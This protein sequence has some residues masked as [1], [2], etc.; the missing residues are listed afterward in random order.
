MQVF[1]TVAEAADRA[2]SHVIVTTKALPEIRSTSSLLAPLLSADKGSYS[3]PTFVLLQNGLSVEK[4]LYETIKTLDWGEPRI[5]STALWIGTNLLD[6]NVVDHSHPVSNHNYMYVYRLVTR[7]GRSACLL[8]C[9]GLGIVPMLPTPL[10]KLRFCRG[11][12]TF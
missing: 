4:D 12:P 1:R 2:Y 8:A 7:N 11:S 6:G 9:I 10:K 5:I 3:L